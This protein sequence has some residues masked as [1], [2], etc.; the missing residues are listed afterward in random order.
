VTEDVDGA[1]GVGGSSTVKPIL[2]FSSKERVKDGRRVG[3][4]F[5]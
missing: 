4:N 3:E 2:R 1:E 5:D